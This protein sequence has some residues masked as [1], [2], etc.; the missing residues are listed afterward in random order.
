MD[1]T[2]DSSVDWVT[3]VATTLDGRNEL[4]SHYEKLSHQFSVLGY[5][6]RPTRFKGYE[7]NTI[8]GLTLGSREDSAILIGMGATAGDVLYSGLPRMVRCTRFDARV[9][10]LLEQAREF[11]AGDVATEWR[12]GYKVGRAV[13]K[14]VLTTNFDGGQTVYFGRRDGRYLLRFYD[15]GAKTGRAP[16]GKVW[17]A[18]VQFN[19]EAAEAAWALMKRPNASIKALCR[20]LVF[21]KFKAMDIIPSGDLEPGSSKLEFSTK[22]FDPSAS[23][24]WI[25]T[26]VR[27]AIARLIEAGHVLEVREALGYYTQIYMFD[28]EVF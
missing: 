17:R 8:N 20:A 4:V 23:I 18:E 6:T 5:K 3:F 14:P 15:R 9:D 19:K 11:W 26:S 2:Y 13:Y 25:R 10:I 12:E 1:T 28:E 16:N 24:E 22:A 21:D 27:P 7:G